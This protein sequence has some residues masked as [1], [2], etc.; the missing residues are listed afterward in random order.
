MSLRTKTTKD[1]ITA[2]KKF[3]WKKLSNWLKPETCIPNIVG[4]REGIVRREKRA[5]GGTAGFLYGRGR[6]F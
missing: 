4:Y 2:E 3:V 5:L 6:G 1:R